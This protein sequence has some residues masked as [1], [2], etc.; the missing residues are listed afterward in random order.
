MNHLNHLLFT[1]LIHPALQL[2]QI[3]NIVHSFV[4]CLVYRIQAERLINKN[5]LLSSN[6]NKY[7][8]EVLLLQILKEVT[9]INTVCNFLVL[10]IILFLKFIH[11]L[12]KIES[13]QL[14]H[15]QHVQPIAKLS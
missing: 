6:L 1:P 15:L 2:K 3:I 13:H 4:I 14:L 5:Q 7:A 11:Q 12:L 10:I 9:D 8:L